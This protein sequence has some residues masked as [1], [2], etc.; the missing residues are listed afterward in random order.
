[1]AEETR[2]SRRGRG[3]RDGAA[4][5]RRSKHRKNVGQNGYKN[6][7]SAALGGF[8][9]RFERRGEDGPSR[10]S[11][12]SPR[13]ALRRRR[14]GAREGVAVRR[15]LRRGA[16][17]ADGD[18][19]G[20]AIDPSGLF[21]EDAPSLFDETPPAASVRRRG[22]EPGVG[23][24]NNQNRRLATRRPRAGALREGKPRGL[25]RRARGF[26]ASPENANANANAAPG[27][28][29]GDVHDEETTAL[30]ALLRVAAAQDDAKRAGNDA[31]R[32]GRFDDAEA[33]YAEAVDAAFTNV[34]DDET[35]A[36]GAAPGWFS[37]RRFIRR[38][39]AWARRRCA[40]PRSACATAPPR[41]RAPVTSSTRSPFAARRSRST[42]REENRRFAERKFPERSG[43]VPTP[44]T[45]TE[46]SCGCSRGRPRCVGVGAIL[47]ECG[48]LIRCRTRAPAST[49]SR[50]SR[51]RAA[52]RRTRASRPRRESIR[53]PPGSLRDP[54]AR[55]TRR[56]RHRHA[57]TGRVACS[58]RTFDLRTERSRFVT[59]PTR[60]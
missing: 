13:A 44:R 39:R 33:R 21:D 5:R 49:S 12:A 29:S 52:L 6:G 47:L 7:S 25:R 42:P 37:G 27:V 46:R 43:Y 19:F 8:D 50:T 56:R 3:C 17:A 34:S 18:G 53:R 54:R 51:R 55:A 9:S 48:V 14:R 28:R 35:R 41:R 57:R 10:R 31:F 2:D 32:A 20:G 24:E 11:A 22:F 59:T 58:E 16:R 30:A 1:M 60:L 36:K 26:G 15:C 23:R 40:S 38:R 4:R 45:I